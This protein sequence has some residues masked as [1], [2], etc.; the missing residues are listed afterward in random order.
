MSRIH[1]ALKK[2][3]QERAAV[4]AGE[5]SAPAHEPQHAPGQ[6]PEA[7]DAAMAPSPAAH[8]SLPPT[9]TAAPATSG[10]LRFEDVRSRCAQ[11][12]WHPDASASVF[13]NAAGSAHGAE[14]FRTLR[15][16]LYQMGSN[17][18][19]PLRR[20]LI[21]SSIPAEGKTYVTH[22]L[23]QSIIRQ[24]DRRVLLIDGDLRCSRLHLPLGALPAPGLT[25]Y[26]RGDVDEVS[27][28]Q[29]SAEGNL[30]F[31]P[32]GDAAPNPSELL[33]NGRLK[34]LLDCL[35]PMFDWVIMDS[36]PCLPVADA[37][38]LAE[39][40]DGVLLVVRAESTPADIARRACQELQ[41]KNV[42]GVVLNAA[43][44]VDTYGLYSYNYYTY[45]PGQANPA[46][47]VASVSAP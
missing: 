11:P 27:V 8:D 5:A 41:G 33:A 18:N 19:A 35:A 14:Q 44:E 20:L 46:E 36:P 30:F 1:D 26:L 16:R 2:A 28:I 34:I 29:R 17:G 32:G 23:A 10:Y 40:C 45:G 7:H 9:L 38:V 22:N 37:S 12:E 4:L 21:T 15:S 25:E 13:T 42:I 47:A 24:P 3:E 39:H 6:T 31:I 43:I